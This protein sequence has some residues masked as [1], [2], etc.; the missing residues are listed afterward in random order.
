[1]FK[2]YVR[3]LRGKKRPKSTFLVILLL[4]GS[5]M[6]HLLKKER[7]S[8]K[9]AY[10]RKRTNFSIASVSSFRVWSYYFSF[11]FFDPVLSIL[12]TANFNL[13]K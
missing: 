6:T 3:E 13:S 12:K 7:I 2:N 10:N 11:K 5:N 4:W 9:V 8:S 1:M